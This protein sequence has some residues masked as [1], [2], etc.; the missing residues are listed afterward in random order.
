MLLLGGC[1]SGVRLG[2]QKDFANIVD[3]QC[4][5]R[6]LRSVSA[7]VKRSTYTVEG[8]GRRFPRGAQVTQFYYD[9]AVTPHGSYTLDLGLLPNGKTRLV[10]DWAKLGKEIPADERAQ[11]MPLL[12]RANNAL[13]RLCNLSFAGSQ[14]EVGP[15]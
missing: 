13:A 12:H 1:D 2:W 11:V 15:G 10:H 9:N 14:L 6:A 3:D 4:V 5:E 7:D 8:G